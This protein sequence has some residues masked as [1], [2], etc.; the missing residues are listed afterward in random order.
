MNHTA[1]K[2][3]SGLN[4]GSWSCE[5]VKL[6]IAQLFIW[7]QVNGMLL[8]TSVSRLY[9]IQ[10]LLGP[11]YKGKWG[12]HDLARIS[13]RG[14]TQMSFLSCFQSRCK[15]GP[16]EW[17]N[18]WYGSIII[19]FANHQFWPSNH[20]HISQYDAL[21]AIWSCIYYCC[22]RFHV[23]LFNGLYYKY[24]TICCGSQYDDVCCQLHWK[25]LD[26]NT[27]A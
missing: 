13:S 9:S 25:L 10:Y 21:N 15:L 2:L 1:N 19:A 3:S 11:A 5:V 4:Q 26:W 27:S 23:I 14:M 20:H 8:L 7:Q 22:I 12:V 18:L 24:Q 16:C 17:K 6:L